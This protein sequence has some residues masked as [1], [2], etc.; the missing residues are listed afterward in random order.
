MRIPRPHTKLW[1]RASS[2]RQ[3]R[4]SEI[5]RNNNGNLPD[6]FF[7][8]V[9]KRRSEA[10]GLR[11]AACA[12]QIPIFVFLALSLVSIETKLLD[13]DALSRHLRE[14]LI[15]VSAALGL[16]IGVIGYYHD[17]LTEIL[18]AYV[19][20]RSK[21]RKSVEEILRIS[22]GIDIF[23]L[24]PLKQ[25]H[26]QLGWGYLWFI[27]IFKTLTVA[28]LIVLGVGALFIRFKVLEDIYFAPTFST[29]VS[30]CVIGFV[31]ISDALGICIFILNTG[32]IL[33]RSEGASQP[34]Q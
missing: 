2:L 8:D 12:V 34:R 20:Y 28:T 26:L 24:P 14:I 10:S 11:L 32:P 22:Y 9:E 13:L 27:R 30:L 23:P 17:V 5:I 29:S 6:R 15:V 21:E 3:A 16:C 33:A 18:A 19:E 4:Y 31:V 1:I 25:G 7:E